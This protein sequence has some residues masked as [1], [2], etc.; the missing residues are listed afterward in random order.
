MA[1]IRPPANAAPAAQS[2]STEEKQCT[3]FVLRSQSVISLPGRYVFSCCNLRFSW[4]LSEEPASWL[5]VPK[6]C[7]ALLC[8]GTSNQCTI[9]KLLPANTCN[10]PIIPMIGKRVQFHDE[11]WQELRLLAAESMSGFHELADEAF[12]DLLKKHGRPTSLKEALRKSAGQTAKVIPLKR[13]SPSHK[14]RSCAPAGHAIGMTFAR[15]FS[16]I[17][18]KLEIVGALSD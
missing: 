5:P 6:P 12:N 17:F 11:T 16:L 3:L 15:D 2:E 10:G 1:G 8:F 13:K 7:V 4:R 18:R 9:H 14:G